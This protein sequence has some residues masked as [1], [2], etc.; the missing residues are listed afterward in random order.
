MARRSILGVDVGT[1]SV[2][3]LAGIIED[4]GKIAIVGSGTVATAGFSKGRIT[5][6]ESLAT[7]AKEAVDCAVMAANVCPDDIYLGIGGMDIAST[8]CIGSVTPMSGGIAA[9][10][11][12]RACRTAAAIA[13]PEGH[14]ILHVLPTGFWVDGEKWT[15]TPV[16]QR[17]ERLE[18]EAHIVSAPKSLIDELVYIL[19]TKGVHITG[20]VANSIAGAEVLATGADEAA[21]LVMDIGAGLTELVLYSGGKAWMSA[22]VPLGGD[23]ITSDIMQGLDVSVCHAEEIK[24]YYGK[25]SKQLYGRDVVLDCNDYGTTDK[26]VAYDFLYKIVESR[27][28]EIVSVAYGYLEPALA[29]HQPEKIILTGGCALQP[30]IGECVEKLFGMPVHTVGLNDKMPDEYAHPSNAAC[31][32]I[33]QYAARMLPQDR[34]SGGKLGSLFRK[35]RDLI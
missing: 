1:G 13:M 29:R 6:F 34:S 9:Q 32:G 28:E 4:E 10:D 8:N 15:G 27:V 22:S 20:V 5:N 21:T 26:Q 11:V 12:D 16:G 33:L 17:C 30:S 18:V 25:L 31:L 14:K 7:A 24:R 35:L 19:S 3:V 2:K 23:Y